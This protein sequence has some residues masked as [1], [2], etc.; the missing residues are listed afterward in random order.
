VT[1]K[2]FQPGHGS[3]W[4]VEERPEGGFTW[5]A[6]GPAGT[7]RGQA[8]TRAEAERA[9]QEAERRLTT[10]PTAGGQAHPERRV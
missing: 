10:D 9:A 1:E 8:D 3:G 2:R 5:T 4:A 6:H 7:L